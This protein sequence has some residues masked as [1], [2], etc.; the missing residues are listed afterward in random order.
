MRARRAALTHR[1]RVTSPFS[2]GAARCSLPVTAVQGPAAA[3]LLTQPLGALS[4]DFLT[5]S[6][7]DTCE[8]SGGA[9]SLRLSTLLCNRKVQVT[10]ASSLQS[11]PGRAAPP[12]HH[13][14]HPYPHPHPA[15]HL[16]SPTPFTCL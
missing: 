7:S 11:A 9:G 16:V 12:P 3:D 6:L 14:P 10:P 8:R 2:A 5:L 15:S 1:F 4:P 13:Q